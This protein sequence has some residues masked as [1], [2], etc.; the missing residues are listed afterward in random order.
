MSRRYIG[1]E[2]LNLNA[3]QRAA[4][5]AALREL[6]RNSAHPNPCNRNHRRVRPDGL[7]VIFE[8]DWRTEDWTVESV[9]GYLADV[10]GINPA[11]IDSAVAQ[12]VY[13]T[14]A[15]F[16]A[17]GTDYLRVIV[18]GG[19]ASEYAQSHAAVLAYLAANRDEW[20]SDAL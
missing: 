4:L 5:I 10:F 20:E 14:L 3:A 17:G 2:S 15:T 12:I 13:G 1:I 7:A 18:F 19:V 16:S 11:N 6:G 8:A 9:T